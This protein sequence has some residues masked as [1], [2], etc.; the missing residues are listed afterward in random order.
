MMTK[1]TM[2]MA[3]E[4]TTTVAKAKDTSAPK[5]K[6]R[7]QSKSIAKYLRLTER[8]AGILYSRRLYEGYIHKIDL[9]NVKRAKERKHSKGD[10]ATEE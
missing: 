7:N 3:K 2:K 1:E 10:D 9:E 8:R 4:K 5:Q 6:I